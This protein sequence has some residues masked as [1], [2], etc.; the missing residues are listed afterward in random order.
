MNYRQTCEE[1]NKV[2]F[3]SKRDALNSLVGQLKSKRVRVY[4]CTAHPGKVHL[5]KE[6]AKYKADLNRHRK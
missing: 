2:L 6:G 4:G 1:H 5:T 3:S